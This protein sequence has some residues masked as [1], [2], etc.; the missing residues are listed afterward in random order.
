VPAY[1]T[2]QANEWDPPDAVH[3]ALLKYWH[4]RWQAE[5][6]S[7][8]TGIMEMRV[9]QPPT[10][11]EEAFMLAKE[12]YVYDPDLVDQGPARGIRHLAR[13]LLNSQ[14]WYFWWD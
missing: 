9:I 10:T 12:Q 13:M 6:V 8:N 14:V 11:F 7:L 2:A 4:E 3:V 5:V 1:L